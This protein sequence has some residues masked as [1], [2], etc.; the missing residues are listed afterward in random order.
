MRLGQLP[1]AVD[2]KIE[3][4]SPFPAVTTSFGFQKFS[5]NLHVPTI[6]KVTFIDQIPVQMF[7]FSCSSSI[8]PLQLIHFSC[9]S[10]VVHVNV[11][12]T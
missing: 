9:S 6:A 12:R 10:S 2:H 8:V 3:Y 4:W 11:L 5:I 1:R 7:L